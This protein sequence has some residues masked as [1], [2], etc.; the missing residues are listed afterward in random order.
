MKREL[1]QIEA[2][3]GDIGYRPISVAG[4]RASGMRNFA[5][6]TTAGAGFSGPMAGDEGGMAGVGVAEDTEGGAWAGAGGVQADMM[7][8]MASMVQAQAEAAE[9]G[10]TYRPERQGLVGVRDMDVVMDASDHPLGSIPTQHDVD[11]DGGTNTTTTAEGGLPTSSV[12]TTTTAMA[13]AP[14]MPTQ[15]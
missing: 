12:T 13:A 3:A 10:A 2:N 1:E 14:M 6:V 7:A 8:A 15:T 11:V 9:Q 5:Q 4:G